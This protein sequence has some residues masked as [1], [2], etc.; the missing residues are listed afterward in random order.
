MG[1][2]KEIVDEKPFG[3]LGTP[4]RGADYIRWLIPVLNSKIK[5]TS[6]DFIIVFSFHFFWIP[7]NIGF[8][9]MKSH[10]YYSCQNKNIGFWIVMSQNAPWCWKMCQH[11]QKTQHH[12]TFLGFY[13]WCFFRFPIENQAKKHGFWCRKSA[14]SQWGSR[15][16]HMPGSLA[17]LSGNA[18][19]ASCSSLAK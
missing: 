5:N 18:A 6:S 14:N 16:L 7:K 12:P 9:N 17:C 1:S 15:P 8:L 3:K 19:G 13:E 2:H 11:V 10:V 4:S